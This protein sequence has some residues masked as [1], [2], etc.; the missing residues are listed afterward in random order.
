MS[1]T[2]FRLELLRRMVDLGHEV[3]AFAPDITPE[4]ARELQSIGVSHHEIPMSRAGINPR[5]D[6][7]TLRVLTDELRSFRPDVVLPYTMKPII[8]GNIAARRAGVKRRYALFTG[9]GY[10][11]SEEA[12]TGKRALVRFLAIWL[13]R[14]ALKNLDLG[15][16]YNPVEEADIR[17]FG[18]V[19][20]DVALL[21][22]P[23]S[24]VDLSRY[25]NCPQPDGPV[26]FLMI[27]RLLKSK[28]IDIYVEAARIL[29]DRGIM[30]EVT[31]LG[32]LDANPDSYRPCDVEAWQAENILTYL[33]ATDDVRPFI[34]AASVIVL[35]AI[36]RE[37]MPRTVLEGMSMGRAVITTDVPG[38]A[39]SIIDGEDGFIV[40]AGDAVALAD[41]M[42]RLATEQGLAAAMGT[43]GRQRAEQVFDVHIVNKT[44]LT[45]MGLEGT[46]P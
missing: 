5:E 38:C 33:G 21:Q 25:E 46:A 14:R 22:V 26:R 10:A 41:A 37:G 23:G 19:P 15:F 7:T 13:Y 17:R 3:R 35:P 18:L 42:Q 16:V 29:R 36:H 27:A 39:H 20:P 11:F 6:M 4:T 43:S 24:G 1:L 34:K 44:L 45:A 12:P 28:G 32:P 40:P 8:Y 30:A 9:L 2:N 31:L